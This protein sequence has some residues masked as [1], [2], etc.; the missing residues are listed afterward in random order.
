M[1]VIM[2]YMIDYNICTGVNC[3]SGY[4]LLKE[5]EERQWQTATERQQITS[6][7]KNIEKL[8]KRLKKG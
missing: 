8:K 2:N 1:E 3:K 4:H 6:V 7:E 5:D